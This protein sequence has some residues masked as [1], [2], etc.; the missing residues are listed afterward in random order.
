MP[1]PRTSEIE[2]THLNLKKYHFC[3]PVLK[4]EFKEG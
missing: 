2:D 4:P 1:M 3:Y